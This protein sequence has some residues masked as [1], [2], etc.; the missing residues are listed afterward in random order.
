M[1]VEEAHKCAKLAKDIRTEGSSTWTG[2]GMSWTWLCPA[3]RNVGPSGQ[4]VR[5]YGRR[6]D[7]SGFGQVEMDEVK[8]DLD[9]TGN[10]MDLVRSSSSYVWASGMVNTGGAARPEVGPGRRPD[11]LRA[12]GS[13]GFKI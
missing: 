5:P 6:E 11:L 10:E 4:R 12:S 7:P 1:A 8:N 3:G 2:C 13:L 9:L